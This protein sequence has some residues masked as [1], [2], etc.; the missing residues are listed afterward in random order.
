MGVADG[1]LD[2]LVMNDC[3]IG[4]V[5]FIPGRGNVSSWRGFSHRGSH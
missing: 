2:S 1:S 4:F 5:G 3:G